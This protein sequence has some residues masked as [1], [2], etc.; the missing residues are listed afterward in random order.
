VAGAATRRTPGAAFGRRA[1]AIQ[2]PCT[3]HNLNTDRVGNT[4]HP[5]NPYKLVT[6]HAFI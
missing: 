6:P 2:V 4:C 5:C 3:G 1:G